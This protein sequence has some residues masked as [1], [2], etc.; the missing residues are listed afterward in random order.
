VSEAAWLVVLL[1]STSSR[2]SRRHT[3]QPRLRPPGGASLFWADAPE[4][5]DLPPERRASLFWASAPEKG[6]LALAF[7][8]VARMPPAPPGRSQC[9][10]AGSG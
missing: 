5:G 4:K 9:D 2:R 7:R 10:A 3:V 1:T 6:D 8:G